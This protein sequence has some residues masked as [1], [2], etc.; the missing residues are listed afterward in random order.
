MLPSKEEQDSMLADQ[1]ANYPPSLLDFLIPLGVLLSLTV[2]PILFFGTSLINEAFMASLLSA[3]F[4]AAIRGMK[5][6]IIMD[7][8]IDGCKTMTIGAIILG[9]AVTI[10][11]V[12][13][14]LHTAAFLVSQIG[15]QIPAIALPAVL[16][17]LCMVIAF[18]CG[19]SW[20]TYA[21]V[22]PI[23]MP[24]AWSI[25]R[26]P[27]SWPSVSV[28]CLAELFSVISVHPSPI[29]P[30]SRR[31]SQAVISWIMSILSGRLP[32]IA[33]S[34][35]CLASTFVLGWYSKLEDQK[36]ENNRAVI[37]LLRDRACEVQ[38][39]RLLWFIFSTLINIKE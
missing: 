3:I 17:V 9:L 20:G 29:Q 39:R 22:F 18:S 4:V 1:A 31:C 11:H 28:Q 6:G 26:T 25:N 30:S 32:S 36:R 24:L 35:G 16:T 10:G 14:E 23:A 2:I 37:L 34:L 12:S 27:N 5:A 13:K 19:T 15:D 21:V 33:A 38:Y 8:F 7:A